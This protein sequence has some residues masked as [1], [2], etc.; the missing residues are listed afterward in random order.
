MRKKVIV[1]FLVIVAALSFSI[2][3]VRNPAEILEFGT[4]VGASFGTFFS[5]DW[6]TTFCIYY[7]EQENSMNGILYLKTENSSLEKLN[8]VGYELKGNA[9]S[10]DWGANFSFNK[11]TQ[12]STESLAFNIGIGFR[13]NVNDYLT[14]GAFVEELPLYSQKPFSF[15]VPNIGFE[16]NFGT[17]NISVYSA[18]NYIKQEYLQ[19]NIGPV[20]SL[21]NFYFDIYWVPEYVINTEAMFYKVMGNASFKINNLK[22]SIYGFYSFDRNTIIDL[23]MHYENAYYGYKVNV[24]VNF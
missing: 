3:I 18:I 9:E 7:S 11:L 16:L 13:A 14:I 4:S 2:R 22:A 20:L 10:F 5:N 19:F 12:D 1:F 8:E 21:N 6:L 17:K 15:F 24:E 23:P